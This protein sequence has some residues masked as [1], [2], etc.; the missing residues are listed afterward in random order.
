M[1]GATNF[2]LT[3][4]ILGVVAL[5][6]STVC[7]KLYNKCDRLEKEKSD[8]QE[9]RRLDQKETTEKVLPV[10][11]SFSQTASMIYDKLETSKQGRR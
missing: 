10:M 5:A 11:S 6:L 4:G 9:A 3:Q 8:L 2:L 1:D 7:I